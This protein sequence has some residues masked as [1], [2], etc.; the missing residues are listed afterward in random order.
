MDLILK[1]RELGYNIFDLNGSFYN[2]IC[3]VFSYNNT[4]FSLSERKNIIV[5]SD[6]NLC[7]NDCNYSYYDIKT[8]R[9]VCL[10]KIGLG[11]NDGYK[12]DNKNDNNKDNKD[13]VNLVKQNIDISK[14]SN[15][16][17]VKCFSIIF[18]KN[19]FT[20]N[21]GFYI[22]LLLL[23]INMTT[24][25]FS[26]ISKIEKTLNEYCNKILGNMKIIYINNNVDLLKNKTT[27]KFENNKNQRNKIKKPMIKD[28]TLNSDGDKT[29][30]SFKNNIL[31]NSDIISEG[32]EKEKIKIKTLKEKKNSDFYVY[33]LIKI[34]KPGKRKEYLS[35]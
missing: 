9:T 20:E 6:E 14:S 21:Y 19:L 18:R 30:I 2:D 16:K 10:C 11:E 7:L 32:D 23:L 25:I 13:I 26:P 17:V 31:N 8:L 4:D 24:L 35:E 15:I 33:Y 1:T 28:N 22:M 27:K 3:S 5:L 12:L 29:D 34:I